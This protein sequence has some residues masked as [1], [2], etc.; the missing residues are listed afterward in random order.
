MPDVTDFILKL[1]R[2]YFSASY[3]LSLSID[4]EVMQ[5]VFFWLIRCEIVGE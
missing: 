2:R 3:P 5:I 1:Q 4:S